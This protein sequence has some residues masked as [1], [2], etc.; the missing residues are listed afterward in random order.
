MNVVWH[1]IDANKFLFFVLN[2][3]C[4]VFIKFVFVVVTY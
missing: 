2:Y 3:S 4:D 1:P